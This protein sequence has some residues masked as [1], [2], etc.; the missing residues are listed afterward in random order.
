MKAV[1][2]SAV[3]LLFVAALYTVM[4]W[5]TGP[6]LDNW[7]F[8]SVWNDYCPRGGTLQGWFRYCLELRDND[9]WRLANLMAPFTTVA[10]PGAGFFAVVTGLCM[11][12]SVWLCARLSGAVTAG[13]T[14]AVWLLLTIALP[15]RNNLLV[16][17]YAI[18]YIVSGT[19]LLTLM[20]LALR[21][22]PARQAT[23]LHPH[24]LHPKTAH[25]KTCVWLLGAGAV[26]LCLWHEGFGVPLGIGLAVLALR[27]RGRVRWSLGAVVVTMAVVTVLWVS[28]SH[29]VQRGARELQQ[30][31]LLENP[32][33]CVINNW[34]TF[35]MIGLYAALACRARGRRFL[36]KLWHNPAFVL[37]A[38]TS[39]GGLAVSCTVALTPR[40]AYCAELCAVAAAM[41][42]WRQ[43]GWRLPR[44]R[45]LTA[46]TAVALA[47]QGVF[48]A[49]WMY[50]LD[51]QNRNI[52][53]QIET[54]AGGTAWFDSLMYPE[55]VPIA[56][57]YM[58]ART[59]FVEPY[60]YFGLSGKYTPKNPVVLPADLRRFQPAR[61]A[62]PGVTLQ[63]RYGLT[64]DSAAVG[65]G[66]GLRSFN[67]TADITLTDG[68][69]LPQHTVFALRYHDA[70]GRARYLLKPARVAPHRVRTLCPQ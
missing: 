19:M 43:S 23:T 7:V 55:D 63:G 44:A 45:F 58:P 4:Q 27:A 31:A 49:Y 5:L 61:P 13:R 25:F 10:W 47:V 46:V 67:F 8:D 33:K 6:Q 26:F 15:W 41:A 64:A 14:V 21:A 40:T 11:A 1:R 59:T 52:L 42:M 70:D 37:A 56:T 66:D 54:D 34:L 22:M 24:G 62:G 51:C 38:A 30:P 16:S 48:A 29:M 2:S 35:G 9:N 50:L 36:K 18:N 20:A 39:V 32:I 53:H 65:P 12:V 60:S 28:A 57:L 69:R 17:D 68:T 3:I